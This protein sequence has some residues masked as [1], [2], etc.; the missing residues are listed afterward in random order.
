MAPKGKL[1]MPSLGGGLTSKAKSGGG[2]TATHTDKI[3]LNTYTTTQKVTVYG[4]P[5]EPPAVALPTSQT[6][7]LV[8]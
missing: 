5:D 1:I 6:G 8:P 2:G 7:I 3:P 4:T